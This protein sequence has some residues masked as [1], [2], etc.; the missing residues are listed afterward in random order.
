MISENIFITIKANLGAIEELLNQATLLINLVESDQRNN[1]Q[2]DRYVRQ[3]NAL[4]KDIAKITAKND[5]FIKDLIKDLMDQFTITT[6]IHQPVLR[7]EGRLESAIVPVTQVIKCD[8]GFFDLSDLTDDQRFRN[9]IIDSLKEAFSAHDLIL[10]DIRIKKGSIEIQYVVSATTEWI[11]A[12]GVAYVAVS[13]YKDFKIGVRELLKDVH[14]ITKA[15]EKKIRSI[16][17]DM[18]LTE[19]DQNKHLK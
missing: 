9:G 11:A 1:K 6:T 15:L 12:A 4:K 13:Q 10:E 16:V 14:S 2:R 18:L 7:E 3:I 19:G 17:V 5:K 8:D